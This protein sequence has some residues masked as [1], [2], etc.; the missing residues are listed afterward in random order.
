M[1]RFSASIRDKI[2]FY[3][4]LYID[5]RTDD[6]F[7]VGK[8]CGNRAFSHLRATRDSEKNR[9]IR[10]IRNDGFEPRIEILVHGLDD[11]ST[12]HKIEA[13]II[14]LLGIDS[15]T[16]IQAGYEAREFGRMS[17]EQLRALYGAAKVVI[18]EPAILININ[19]SFRY[20]M[21]P[22]ELYDATRSAWVVGTKRDEPSLAF[23]VYQGIV[24]E[25]YQIAHWFQN[26][27]TL[28]SLKTPDEDPR[29]ERWEFVGQIADNRTRN[30][31]RYNN[32]S[33]YMGPR[34]PINYVNCD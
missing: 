17:V 14:D 15:L 29:E 28:N 12:A 10:D 30:R 7:Y 8:G 19:K 20:G 4:Y 1:N 33:D 5:P 21:S 11:E 22:V 31:Y 18:R 23:A 26:N 16:N 9:R 13:S 32:V 24:Q 27:A 2:K 25:V 34:N 3:V 6:I